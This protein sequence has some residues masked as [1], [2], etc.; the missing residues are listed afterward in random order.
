M[1][2]DYL[3]VVKP[4]ALQA[5]D[6][7]STLPTPW[8]LDA[9]R[10]ARSLLRLLDNPDAIAQACFGT[11]GQVAFLRAWAYRDPAAVA[12]FTIDLYAKGSAKIGDYAVSASSEHLAS[13]WMQIPQVPDPA[14]Y[15][16]GQWGVGN[17]ITESV[18][19]VCGALAATE[20]GSFE[21]CTLSGYIFPPL[22]ISTFGGQPASDLTTLTLPAEFKRWLEKTGC[23]P[24]GVEDRTSIVG[25]K[26]LADDGVITSDFDSSMDV[27]LCI[28]ANLFTSA[29]VTP[30]CS[31]PGAVGAPLEWF[32]NHWVVLK[33]KIILSAGTVYMNLWSWGGHY[34][35]RLALADFNASYHG[36]VTARA[37]SP[38]R[39]VS[40][41]PATQAVGL[42]RIYYSQDNQLHAEWVHAQSGVEWCELN[43]VQLAMVPAPAGGGM[44]TVRDTLQRRWVAD[45]LGMGHITVPMPNPLAAHG[46]RCELVACRADLW[47]HDCDAS[48]YNFH[49]I[50]PCNLPGHYGYSAPRKPLCETQTT[51]LRLRYYGYP[52]PQQIPDGLDPYTTD[53]AQRADQVVQFDGET[54]G[55]CRQSG[56]TE[57]VLNGSTVVVG[58]DA[59][60]PLSIQRVAVCFEYFCALLASGP[61][62]LECLKDGQRIE[63]TLGE[64]FSVQ[65]LPS[66]TPTIGIDFPAAQAALP[67]LCLKALLALEVARK[68][69]LPDWVLPGFVA[70][71]AV[72]QTTVATPSPIG[73]ADFGAAIKPC[74]AALV[75]QAQW[76]AAHGGRSLQVDVRKSLNPALPACVFI[77]LANRSMVDASVEL[78]LS[79][80]SPDGVA[81]RIPVTLGSSADRQFFHGTFQTKNSWA[82]DYTIGLAFKGK[83]SW[84]SKVL[85]ALLGD[86]FDANPAT[87]AC[88][89]PTSS[90][91][92][93]TTGYESGAD[94]NH[95]VEVGPLSRFAT[96]ARLTPDVLDNTTPNNSFA[97][98]TRVT[99]LILANKSSAPGTA[100]SVEKRFDRLNFHDAQD[101][102]YFDVSYQCPVSDDSDAANQPASS[103]GSPLLG[104]SCSHR[105]PELTCHVKPDDFRC[106]D[107]AAY[108]NGDTTP[109]LLVSEARSAGITITSPSRSLGAKRC[110]F[111]LENHD[112]AAA[113]AFFYTARFVYTSAFST[114]TVDTHA[115]AYGGR[116][117]DSRKFLERLY[118]RLDLPRPEEYGSHVLH[119]QNPVEFIERFS[120]FV[121]EPE[122][123]TWLAHALKRSGGMVVAESLHALGQAACVFGRAEE[124]GGLFRQSS[125]IALAMGDRAAT[126]SALESLAGL[127]KSLGERDRYT[128][129]RKEISSLKRRVLPKR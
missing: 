19:M 32:P 103:G 79:G 74:E 123:A 76:K 60:T 93:A 43:R 73:F 10:V 17:R 39:E 26:S 63:I 104:F 101:A 112:F 75:Y 102:D 9:F 21:H 77:E 45:S 33:D 121:Q 27:F 116:L 49:R 98:A 47:P 54:L 8:Q 68:G 107:L 87:L 109:V 7:M 95:Q 66:Q 14:V 44:V 13:T 40:K 11:C 67:A 82:A 15:A 36:C 117:T 80:R 24:G 105:P 106:M 1:S 115:P 18:W 129:V 52:G 3:P 127:H 46:T 119:V 84:P 92:L 97:T 126:I 29:T 12:R 108:K 111:V 5:F 71:V 48:S 51:H 91:P 16:S 31:P 85:T 42:P 88:L 128:A 53:G 114:M 86:T 89:N 58:T 72:V 96:V 122:T 124:A 64:G 81:V 2:Y 94:A 99:S 28:N 37:A 113:G 38:R 120:K 23:Y 69:R 6:P 118:D 56:Q 70:R 83:R 25:G 35:V 41:P 59:R 55:H 100:A 61:L 34:A 78:E 65:A 62:A 57:I 20:A 22:P 4:F 90:G 125:G 110:H 30:A 50:V